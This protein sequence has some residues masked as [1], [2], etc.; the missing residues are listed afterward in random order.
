MPRKQ[1]TIPVRSLAEE[2]G[3]GIALVQVL[4]GAFQSD[5]EIK[6]AHRDN[7]HVFFMLEEGTALFEVD[8]QEHRLIS[9]SLMYIQPYQ[10]HKGLAV[11][12]VAF[13]ALLISQENL[14][15]EY[16]RILEGIAPAKP[17]PLNKEVFSLISEAASL[18]IK[19]H[20]R[21]NERLYHS[22][23]KDSCNALAALVASQYLVQ[24]KPPDALSRYEI[25]ARAF[26]TSLE[27][28]FLTEKRPSGYAGKLKIS[29]PYLNECVK[30]VTGYPVSHHIQQRV[31]LEAKRLLYHTDKSVKEITIEL[32]YEDYAYF[33]RLFTKITG[34]SALAFRNKNRD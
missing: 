6:Q 12:S 22:M 17:L 29:V 14:N 20:K 18:C 25:I 24:S 13:T 1:K 16:L 15:P 21:K 28:F 5:E 9:P 34:R 8:F 23:L 33:S 19:F 2:P 10:V 32:G 31:I 7:Y 3:K 30:N 11:D 27:R 26:K 4:S